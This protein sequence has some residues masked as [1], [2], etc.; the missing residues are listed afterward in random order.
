MS[1]F[2]G[3]ARKVDQI[4]KKAF[5]EYR[6]AEN[7]LKEAKQKA[8]EYP[9]RGGMVNAEYAAKSARAQADYIEAKEAFSQAKK[10]FESHKSEIAAIRKELA[11]ELNDYY[12]ADPATLDSNT[13]EL[14]KTGILKPHEYTKLMN[15]AQAAGNYTMQR[16]IAKYASEAAEAEGKRS[17]ENSE[18]ARELRAISYTATQ[19]AGGDH[20]RA[21]DVLADVYDRAVNNP[22]MIDHWDEL[23]AETTENF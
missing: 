22:G 12:A 4:A 3:Y 8:S 5:A 13:L 14:M 6:A 7:A 19:N 16:M 1:K 9:H 18:T 21:F 11:A 2:N 17:G 15:E 23:T 10:A 20:L